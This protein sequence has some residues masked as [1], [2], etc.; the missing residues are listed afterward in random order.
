MKK[1]LLSLITSAAVTLGAYADSGTWTIANGNMSN[2]LTA[3]VKITSVIYQ[4]STTNTAT[5]AAVD[6]P[7]ATFTNI[8]AGFSTIT[9][10]A[11]NYIT[12]YTNFFGVSNSFTNLALI[13]ATNT[14]TAQTNV[15][16]TQFT[17]SA[18]TNA[19]ARVD[20]ANFYFVNGFTVT[21]SGAGP[22]T[23]TVNYNQ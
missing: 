7:S 17:L 21:N 1:L 9:Q 8:L 13:S 18:A 11:T 16:P 3:P 15:Y 14:I 4:S 22:V 23:I 6:S 5:F 10:K 19:Q 12:T 2:L 20:N